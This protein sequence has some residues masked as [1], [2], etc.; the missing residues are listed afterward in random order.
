MLRK[1]PS[2]LVDILRSDGR[3]KK[4]KKALPRVIH[5]AKLGDALGAKSIGL[6][7]CQ[8]PRG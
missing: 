7:V 1:Q 2:I 3:V 6:L 8:R 5:A 4:Y